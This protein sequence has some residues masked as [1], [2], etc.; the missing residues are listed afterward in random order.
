[1]IASTFLAVARHF[2]EIRPLIQ[3]TNDLK[4]AK[5]ANTTNEQFAL[6]E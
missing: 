4:T 6:A 2:E 1:M 5:N 3:G